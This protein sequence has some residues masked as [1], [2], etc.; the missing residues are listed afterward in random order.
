MDAQWFLFDS[1]F[2]VDFQWIASGVLVD[3]KWISH[4]FPI[5][6]QRFLF[7]CLLDQLRIYCGF[8]VGPYGFPVG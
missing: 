4:G 3:S 5:G 7:E 8:P 2:L 6:S 1:L